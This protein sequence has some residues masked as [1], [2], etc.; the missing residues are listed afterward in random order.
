MSTVVKKTRFTLK[1]GFTGI[2]DEIK[3]TLE[4][5]I[6]RG[7][8]SDGTNCKKIWGGFGQINKDDPL[9]LLNRNSS[10]SLA[11]P[12]RSFFNKGPQAPTSL[13]P[14]HD[15]IRL[16]CLLFFVFRLR[17]L[18]IYPD[19]SGFTYHLDP[20]NFGYLFSQYKPGFQ[21][22]I[23]TLIWTCAYVTG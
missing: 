5:W 23:R 11:L 6:Q 9:L 10:L 20:F 13:R 4:R 14:I 3:G 18:V 7:S 17:I 1:S 19:V 15:L 22:G 16:F 12:Y 21:V 2:G 8:Q